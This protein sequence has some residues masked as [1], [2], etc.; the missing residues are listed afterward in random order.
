M[1]DNTKQITPV[2]LSGG[3][4]TRLWPLS[5]ANQPKQFIPLASDRS[6]FE[7]TVER[8]AD[9]A[10]SAPMVLCAQEHR[11]LVKKLLTP[12]ANI[13]I[14][15]EPCGRNTAA[16]IC[17]AALSAEKEEDILLVLPSD[18]YIPQAQDF[19]QT[20]KSALPLAEA[21]SI[22]T[23]GIEPTSPHTGFGYIE[24]GDDFAPGY[25]IKKFHEKPDL[26]KAKSYLE[27]GGYY[28]NAG[29]F[30]MRADIL[31]DEMQAHAADILEGVRAAV[32]KAADDLGDMLLDADAFSKVRSQSIDY[33]VLEKTD[34]AA[35][36]PAGFAW[37]DLGSW[38]ALWQASDRDAQGNHTQGTTYLK[39]VKNS[40]LRSE[41]P[42]LAVLGLEDIV[43][44]A[45]QDAVFIAPKDKSE[46]VK[47]LVEDMKASNAPQANENVKTLRPW[48]GYE[49]MEESEGFKVKKLTVDPGCRLSL[50]KHKHRSEHWVVVK[51]VATVTRDDDIFDLQVNESTYI[52]CGAVHR[53]ENKG[54]AV[55]EIIEVQTGNYLGE[56]DIIR[57]EDD[58][59]R[60]ES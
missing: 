54:M 26:D 9:K 11:F 22:V 48:G 19:V 29:I 56:D 25:R 31:L 12:S 38:D 24:R 36:M 21:G 35:V 59:N 37:S 55:L 41:G 10:F 43:A 44:V 53:L 3:Q 27:Q 42:T 13:K 60:K 4:G 18:H 17:A 45:M 1:T 23:F 15:M 52:P 58:Y 7:D 50:Q 57:L 49:V 14:I 2:I 34:K 30:M 5:R 51:G 20:I 47:A 16:A 46:E 33:A 40:Y 32:N 8:C 28:W 39:D 6:L